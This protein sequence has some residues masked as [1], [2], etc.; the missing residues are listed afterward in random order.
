MEIKIF[1]WYMSI[2]SVYKPGINST[3]SELFKMYDVTNV[4]RAT[5]CMLQK[6]TLNMSLF[7]SSNEYKH[8]CA[9]TEKISQI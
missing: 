5:C 2:L 8:K 6:I 9:V 1:R 3:V 4:N 7:V